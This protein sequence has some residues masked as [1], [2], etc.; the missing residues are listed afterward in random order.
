MSSIN[1]ISESHL[2]WM[3][4]IRVGEIE[5][6]FLRFIQEISKELPYTECWRYGI[7]LLN[8]HS[9]LV[10]RF[11]APNKTNEYAVSWKVDIISSESFSIWKQCCICS[12]HLKHDRSF[13]RRYARIFVNAKTSINRSLALNSIS[14]ANECY[15]LARLIS[16]YYAF[17]KRW[18]ILE[19]HKVKRNKPLF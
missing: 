1:G 4:R 18:Y 16:H 2:Q 13:T 3:F 15:P 5:Y 7:P 11:T 14:V 12:T 10:D 8:S 9:S 19:Q 6:K 17:L